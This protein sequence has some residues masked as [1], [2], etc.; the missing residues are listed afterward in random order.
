[1]VPSQAEGSQPD[2]FPLPCPPG[3]QGF[4]LRSVARLPRPCL[5]STTRES[6]SLCPLPASGFPYR[7]GFSVMSFAASHDRAGG[8][9]WVRRTASPDAVR[10]HIG[11]VH[12]ISGLALTRLLV[13]LPAAIQLVRCSLRTWVLP[14]AS[15]RHPISEYVL[16]LLALPFRPVTA[17]VLLLPTISSFRQKLG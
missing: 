12:R 1:M 4:L 14:H 13:L 8:S 7:A 16:A 17:G 10:L 9:P 3:P 2:S 11:S 6:V 5:F 15:S